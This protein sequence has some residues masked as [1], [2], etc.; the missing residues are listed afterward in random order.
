[1]SERNST[2]DVIV[3]FL[4]GALVGAGVA[5]LLAPQAGQETRKRI[6]EVAGEWKDKGEDLIRRVRNREQEPAS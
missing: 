6:R 5:L 1:M 2:T 3:S 4:A